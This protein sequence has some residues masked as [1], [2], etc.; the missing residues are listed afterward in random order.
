MGGTQTPKGK[1][2][3]ECNGQGVLYWKSIGWKK[4]NGSDRKTTAV[5]P[6]DVGNKIEW[7]EM[8][9]QL[10]LENARF[11][12]EILGKCR[13][14]LGCTPAE[15]ERS[16]LGFVKDACELLEVPFPDDIFTTCS[17]AKAC[18]SILNPATWCCNDE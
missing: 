17:N 8:N 7:K 14:K 18:L 15:E 2:C 16:C 10:F 13:A 6:V 5:N 12:D 3:R 9:K 1:I 11:G 4:T